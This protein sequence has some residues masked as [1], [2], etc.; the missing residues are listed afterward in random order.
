MALAWGVSTSVTSDLNSSMSR[1]LTSAPFS[2]ASDFFSEPR[3]SIAAA[4]ITPCSVDTF[5]SPD[6]FPGV[7]F[8]TTPPLELRMTNYKR[9]ILYDGQQGNFRSSTEYQVPST[10]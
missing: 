7:S 10:E 1:S 6:N 9:V 8:T 4:A 3:W 5:L 2:L